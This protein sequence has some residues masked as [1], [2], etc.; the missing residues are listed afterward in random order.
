MTDGP[1]GVHHVAIQVHDLAAMTAFY[2]DVLGL[3]VLRR[4][5]TPDGTGER[6]IWLDLGGGAFLALERVV[7]DRSGKAAPQPWKSPAPGFHLLALAITRA[8]RL[9]WEARLGAAGVAIAHRTAYT[10]YV[11]DPEGNRVGLSHWPDESI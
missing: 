5:S 2:R 1:T 3:P 9:A 10:L 11:R 7:S 8:A 6:S 4:W